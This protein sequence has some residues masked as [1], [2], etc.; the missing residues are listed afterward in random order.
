MR[1]RLRSEVSYTHLWRELLLHTPYFVS[2]FRPVSITRCLGAT[3]MQIE[4][5][6]VTLDLSQVLRGRAN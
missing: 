1:L 3:S 4:S 2:I 5:T 6:L